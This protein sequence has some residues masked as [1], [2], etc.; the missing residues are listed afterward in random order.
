MPTGQNYPNAGEGW[1]SSPYATTFLEHC[2]QHKVLA[3]VRS[4]GKRHTGD[5]TIL[6]QSRKM[7]CCD[8]TWSDSTKHLGT[9]RHTVG[10]LWRNGPKQGRRDPEFT[11]RQPS[12]ASKSFETALRD[13]EILKSSRRSGP[14]ELKLALRSDLLITEPCSLR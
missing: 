7:S 4:A 1:T 6:D 3:N 9:V 5:S 13:K 2:N 12:L 11:E 10:T 14:A 8:V